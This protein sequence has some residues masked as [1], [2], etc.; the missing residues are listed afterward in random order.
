MKRISYIK[1]LPFALTVLML[2]AC[3]YITS[4]SQSNLKEDTTLYILPDATFQQVM[5]SLSPHLKDKEAFLLMAKTKNY[6]S[7]IKKGMYKLDK[8]LSSLEIVN[9]L[10][11]GDQSEVKVTLK[12]EPTIYHI[13]GAASKNLLSDSLAILNEI[14]SFAKNKNLDDEQIKAYFLPNTYHFFWTDSPQKFV[15]R[16]G[17][18]EKKFWNQE[19]TKALENSGLTKLE[20]ITLASIVQMESNKPKEQPIV[21]G[22]YLNRLKKGI[23]LQSDPTAKYGYLKNTGFKEKIER[24]YYKHLN[25]PSEFNTYQIQGLPPAPIC[26]PNATAIDAV[27]NPEKNDYIFM[28]AS[29]KNPGYHEFAKTESQHAKN[30]EQ[31]HRWL[32]ENGIK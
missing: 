30:V 20:V 14:R 13:A 27:L 4:F 15:E 32:N 19:R 10:R 7:L 3:K 18:E 11:S 22:L 16:M 8:D 24:V 5:D 21:A 1:Y 31:Y 29:A 17:A 25:S 28:C 12:N 23:K 9:K 6:P 2:N 26:L